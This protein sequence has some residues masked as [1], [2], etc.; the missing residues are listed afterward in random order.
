MK[1]DFTLCVSEPSRAVHHF[2]PGVSASVGL[3]SMTSIL[4][5]VKLLKR[6]SVHGSG[7]DFFFFF[8]PSV[9]VLLLFVLLVCFK[10]YFYPL[11]FSVCY[12]SC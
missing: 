12:C 1:N 10:L 4:E 11:F 2:V 9:F 5:S 7:L 3:F 6:E 8:L